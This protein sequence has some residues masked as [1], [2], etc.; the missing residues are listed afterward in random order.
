M[1]KEKAIALML[2]GYLLLILLCTIALV[3]IEKL[4]ERVDIIE[5]NNLSTVSKNDLETILEGSAK[6]R[7]VVSEL[8]EDF[9]NWDNMWDEMFEGRK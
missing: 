2:L 5:V 8:R 9:S 7:E 3:E 1:S 4:Q 6:D